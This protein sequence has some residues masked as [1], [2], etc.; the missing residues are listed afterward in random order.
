MLAESPVDMVAV[1][2]AGALAVRSSLVRPQQ[3]SCGVEP[4]DERDTQ[5][6][7]WHARHEGTSTSLSIRSR[8]AG[9]SLDFHFRSAQFR[10]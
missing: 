10:I 9:D 8:P 2:S 6:W 3:R 5:I 4:A 1:S 7:Q